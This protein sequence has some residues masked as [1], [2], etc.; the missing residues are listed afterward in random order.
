MSGIGASPFVLLREAPWGAQGEDGSS[1]GRAV[2]SYAAWERYRA[3]KTMTNIED[4]DE[5]RYGAGAPAPVPAPPESERGS[6]DTVL[7]YELH[8]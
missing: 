2:R 6:Q 4:N 3:S 5:H 1:D 8:G 7:D